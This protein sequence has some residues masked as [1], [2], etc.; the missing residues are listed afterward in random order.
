[1]S[2]RVR[3]LP[4]V[5]KNGIMTDS[6]YS[7]VHHWIVKKLGKPKLCAD[8]GTTEDRVYHWANVSGQYKRELSDWRRLCV[9]CH[10]R[11]DGQRKPERKFCKYGH[12]YTPDNLYHYLYKGKWFRRCRKCGVNTNRRYLRRLHESAKR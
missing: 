9:P 3:R 4:L 5:V 1:M 7:M 12:P 2:K 6:E 10:V 8:C 11:A